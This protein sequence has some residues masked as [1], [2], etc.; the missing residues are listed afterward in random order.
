MSITGAAGGKGGNVYLSPHRDDAAFSLGALIAK[1]P[2]GTLV[3]I[4]T[5]SEYLAVPITLG[6]DTPRVDIVS[7]IRAAEDEVFI[8][9]HGLEE[10][11]LGLD[12]PSLRGRDVF[13]DTAQTAPELAM[14]R[15]PLTTVLDALLAVGP[16]PIYC[17]AG[18]GGHVDHLLA[19]RVTVEWA[20]ARGLLGLLRFYEDLPYATKRSVREEGLRRLRGTV[21]AKLRRTA[22]RA[23]SDKL[24]AISLYPSQ[25]RKPPMLKRFKPAALWPIWPHEAVWS[26][27]T[28]T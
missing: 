19:C 1:T 12:E 21:P 27:V 22:W 26:P 7:A 10:R 28:H 15:A 6:G 5:R 24:A 25:H 14:L 16:R 2:G 13:G 18:I 17:P 8:A 9:R 11:N 23:G 3:N 20:T 4:F